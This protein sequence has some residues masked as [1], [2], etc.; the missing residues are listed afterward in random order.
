MKKFLAVGLAVMLMAS[1][2]LTTF[3]A[4]SPS[5]S[6]SS[7]HKSSK[8][9][10]SSSSTASSTSSSS[11]TSKSS[12]SAAAAQAAKDAKAAATYA[13]AQSVKTADGQTVAAGVAV[14]GTTDETAAAFAAVGQVFGV[15]V[16]DTFVYGVV[17]VDP[18]ASVTTTFAA[19]SIPAGSVL[20][21]LDAFGNL[22]L[23]TPTVLADGTISVTLPALC[24]V[25]VSVLPAAPAA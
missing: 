2:S 11:S 16:T 10:S 7:S 4:S 6:S 1:M 8:S 24:Q 18:A 17:G 19:G 22:T 3:A 5:A 9:S 20:M 23:V 15:A 12:A 25:A 21:V 13:P 14:A